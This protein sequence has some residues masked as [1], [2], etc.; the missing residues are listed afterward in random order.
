MTFLALEDFQERC[1]WPWV[2]FRRV[3]STRRQ[4][5][6]RS[7]KPLLSLS[8]SSG[9]QQRP[10]GEDRQPASDETIAK[11]WVVHPGDLVFNPMW[12]IE[13]GVA[14]S[15]TEGAVST[16]YRVYQM[17]TSL[18][19]PFAHHY[20][21]CE[22]ALEQYRLM[23]R[24]VTTFDRSITRS[25][26]EAMPVPLPPLSE[27]CAIAAFLD[28]EVGKVNA[29]IAKKHQLIE[30]LAEYR[31][32]LIT[33]TVTKGLPPEAAEAEEV[34]PSPRQKPS[35]VEWLGEMPEHWESKRLKFLTSTNDDSLSET[36]DPLR[37][38]AYVDIGSVD[39]SAGITHTEDMVFE[40]APSRARR[41]V[42]DGDT[43]ISTV[44]TYLRAIAPIRNPPPDTVVSTGFA[45]IRPQKL[46]SEFATWAFREYGF[47]EEIVARSTGVSYP[48]INA[49]QIGDLPIP[50][51]PRSEQRAI[52]AFLE[53]EAAHIDA[54]SSRVE[55]AIDR[56][57]EYRTALITA[58]VTGKIDVR[59]Y[60]AVET[61]GS[62]A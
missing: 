12:A 54:L 5:N 49:S 7:D 28:Q 10:D 24:G 45:V 53:R 29:L 26:F 39:P 15:Q 32:A 8:A 61:D 62:A 21:R 40:D 50:L 25:D 42:R 30:R 9:I 20:F 58:A 43:I 41:L 46:D 2:E 55:A 3:A 36:E 56:L 57:Q 11:Y 34:D 44:R 4:A 47:I 31:T 33:Q 59:D 18:H 1:N 6:D 48:A 19:P 22:P 51:P 38:I 27:Q 16:A 37:A 17:H 13:G 60:A 35:G 23:I 52:A 14:V